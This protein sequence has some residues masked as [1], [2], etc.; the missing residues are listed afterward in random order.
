H[1]SDGITGPREFLPVGLKWARDFVVALLE[2]EFAFDEQT[3]RAA[4]VIVNFFAL[5]RARQISD[6]PADLL[7]REK[8][9]SALALALGEFPQEIFVGAAEKI[10][11]NIVK[12]ESIT[13]IGKLFH[14][15]P[16]SLIAYFAFA[17]ARFVEINNVDYAAQR[18]IRFH[19]RADSRRE[20]LTKRFWLLIVRPIKLFAPA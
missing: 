18:W 6:E 15:S 14:N 17:A 7:R 9:T 5:T 4:G 11:L 16:Q 8:F 20:L 12:T 10:R 13:R 1:A 2:R 19:D 3:G